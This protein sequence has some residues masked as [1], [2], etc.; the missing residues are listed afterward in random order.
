V[1]KRSKSLSQMIK[2]AFC[3]SANKVEASSPLQRKKLRE[4]SKKKFMQ[5]DIRNNTIK[6]K[7][8]LNLKAKGV[9]IDKAVVQTTCASPCHRKMKESL[10]WQSAEKYQNLVGKIYK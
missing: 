7:Q 5:D 8:T 10:R 4:L 6:L 9:F 2:S 1:L 3:S